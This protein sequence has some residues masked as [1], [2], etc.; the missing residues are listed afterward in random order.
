MAATGQTRFSGRFL[1][2]LVSLASGLVISQFAHWFDRLNSTALFF[3]V[4]GIVAIIWYGTE[5]YYRNEYS[6]DYVRDDHLTGLQATAALLLASVGNRRMTTEVNVKDCRDLYSHERRI[7]KECEQWDGAVREWRQARW[8]YEKKLAAL[9]D[10][11]AFRE[12]R[13]NR[14]E[15]LRA[16]QLIT[17]NR[18]W[19]SQNNNQP[20]QQMVW[21][22]DV[23]PMGSDE[24]PPHDL[25]IRGPQS[26]LF[27]RG[28]DDPNDHFDKDDCERRLITL[29][30]EADS[31]Q[32]LKDWI[33]KEIILDQNKNF[34]NLKEVLHDFGRIV[35]LRHGR[36]CVQC[37]S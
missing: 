3:I 2:A 11:N 29:F 16:F 14:T 36:G 6:R 23:S 21:N 24:P 37:N 1:G 7:M 10:K 20:R 5:W 13:F 27:I 35:H 32:E 33:T 18:E 8:E 19:Y 30:N 15:L 17:R 31:S 26:L 28:F 9:F 12:H 34:M 4:F 22:F 25:L